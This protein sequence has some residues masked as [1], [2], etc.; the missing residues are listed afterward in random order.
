MDFLNP[1]KKRAHKI[2]LYIGYVL[3]ACALIVG[4]TILFFEASGFDLN[5]KTGE[6]IQNGMVFV[7]AHPESASVYI[8]GVQKTTTDARLTIPAGNYTFEFMRQG[9]RT[10]K[11]SFQ[12]VGS[13]I[14]RLSYVFLF[15]EK[16]NPSEIH[17][18]KST[19]PFATQSPD[20]KWLLIQQPENFSTFDVYDLGNQDEPL[21]TS[22]VLPENLMNLK[23]NTNKLELTEWS[24]D[25]RHVLVKHTFDGGNEFILIDRVQPA[26]SLNLN[27]HFNTPIYEVSLRNKKFDSFHI[28]DKDGGVLR[29]A[30]AKSKQLTDIAQKV[31]SFKSYGDDVI[32]YVTGENA[33]KDK[34]NLNIMRGR[35]IFKVRELMAGK[36]YPI[37][38]T[39]YDDEW[40]MAVGSDADNK[41]YIY[42]EV[43]KD[44]DAKPSLT[45]M[46]I[47]VFKMQQPLTDISVSANTRFI[48]VQAG[49]SFAVYDAE[50]DDIVYRYQYDTKLKFTDG[51]KATWMDGHRLTAIIDGKLQVWDFDG[52]NMQTLVSTSPG[53]LPYFDRD[54]DFLYSIAPSEKSVG[55]SSLTKTP[56][57]TEAD[58]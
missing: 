42:N 25:N 2:R 37:D 48:S 18:Y 33:E 6:I 43:F 23:T 22:F 15:P 52:I 58:L 14:E 5:R 16:L 11:R 34:V 47:A 38:I 36:K 26:E 46:P 44:L 50:D 13:Q 12:L 49:S 4:S 41:A 9:Y 40:Y 39:R 7:N 17:S 51:Q 21:I 35:D 10:W 19:P 1:R 27:K 53:F 20:R 56:M 29:F 24:T 45:P 55:Q 28:L 32:F 30:D 8:N 3:I 31:F 54:Y 57:R